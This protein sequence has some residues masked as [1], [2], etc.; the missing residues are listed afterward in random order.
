MFYFLISIAVFLVGFLSG[1]SYSIEGKVFDLTLNIAIAAFFALF[2]L[3]L[4]TAEQRKDDFENIKEEA[5]RYLIWTVRNGIFQEHFGLTRHYLSEPTDDETYKLNNEGIAIAFGAAHTF[6]NLARAA[7]SRGYIEL[8][9]K[10]R[11]IKGYLIEI[12]DS[13]LLTIPPLDRRFQELYNELNN[14]R[15][16][17]GAAYLGVRPPKFHVITVTLND[18]SKH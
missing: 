2:S 10:A 13:H 18:S 17:R 9:N 1:T 3:R 6:S 12:K 7:K 11:E 5:S 14:I 8:G 16:N 4:A 15:P